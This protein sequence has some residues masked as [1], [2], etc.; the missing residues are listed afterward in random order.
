MNKL[1]PNYSKRLGSNGLAQKN[2]IRRN[3][4][5]GKIWP[6]K[7]RSENY[8]KYIVL[9]TTPYFIDQH[10]IS[11]WHRLKMFW[12]VHRD[13]RCTVQIHDQFFN[14]ERPTLRTW[15]EYKIPKTSLNSNDCESHFNA[16]ISMRGFQCADFNVPKFRVEAR[17]RHALPV[18]FHSF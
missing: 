5:Y 4:R 12:I 15:C 16:R 18:N 7:S 17:F 2:E 10:C 3:E 8:D 11:L 1:V 6:K 13:K 9:T 14:N